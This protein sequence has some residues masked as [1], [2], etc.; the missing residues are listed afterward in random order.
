MSLALL[1]ELLLELLLDGCP[2]GAGAAGE[3]LAGLG[4]GGLTPGGASSFAGVP[5]ALALPSPFACRTD[6]GGRDRFLRKLDRDM[7]WASG[8]LAARLAVT[9]WYACSSSLSFLRAEGF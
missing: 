1:E 5:E 9:R 4:G 2:A 6:L 7:R 3:L 8:L